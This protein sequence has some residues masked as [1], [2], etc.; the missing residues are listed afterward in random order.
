MKHIANLSGGKDSTAML[1]MMLD[2]GM[3]VD[4]IVFADTGKDF[5]QMLEH[6]DELEQYIAK[7]YPGAPKITR[8]R[9][10]KSFDYLMFDHVKTRGKNKGKCGYGWASM[11]ARWCTSKLKGEVIDK[12]VASL[13]DDYTQYIGIAVDEPKRLRENPHMRYPLAE[14]NINEAAALEYCYARGFRWGGLYEHFDRVSCWCCPLKNLR[15]LKTLWRHYPELWAELRDMDARAFNNFRADYTVKQLEERFIRE[16]RAE[17][18]D[19]MKQIRA[20]ADALSSDP[21]Q[22]AES[23]K[24]NALVGKVV[25]I[26]FVD[27]GTDV[28][29]L[30][31][32]TSATYMEYPEADN[33]AIKGYYLEKSGGEVYFK[34][35]H[36]VKITPTAGLEED[37]RGSQ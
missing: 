7:H 5:P 20:A 12:F 31:K 26:K 28:G 9:S 29:V 23:K 13:G 4:Y 16:A 32:D 34:K 15:E 22:P 19:K 37:T 2:R 36:V 17:Y 27:G 10:E 24:L 3:P 18:N 35:S 30:H 11:L 14:W 33:T 8:L 6:L 25:E 1:L 21:L